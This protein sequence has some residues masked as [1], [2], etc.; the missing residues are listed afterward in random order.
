[1]GSASSASLAWFIGQV[2]PA[3][4]VEHRSR[5]SLEVRCGLISLCVTARLTFGMVMSGHATEWASP[6]SQSA[7]FKD[8]SIAVIG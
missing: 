1:M 6:K 7:Y 5:L 3:K 2:H 4:S 8:F